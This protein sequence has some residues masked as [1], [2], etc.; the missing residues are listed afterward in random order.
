MSSFPFYDIMMKDTKNTDL[1]LKQK[2]DFLSK[3]V[4]MDKDGRELIYALIRV[5]E[6]NNEDLPSSFKLPYSGK[7]VE[8][9]M[10]FD[11][12]KLPFKLR[13]VLYKF[14]NVHLEKMEEE[15]NKQLLCSSSSSS[16]IKNNSTKEIEHK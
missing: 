3:V 13:Q 4:L 12:E 9:D 2:N 16:S 10:H 1:T 14:I 6:I 7:F 15:K 8:K 5:F 11:L